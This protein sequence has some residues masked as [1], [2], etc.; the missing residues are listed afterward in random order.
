[1]K[2]L[3]EIIQETKE[4]DETPIAPHPEFDAAMKKLGLQHRG[5]H[6]TSHKSGYHKGWSYD[7][8][9]YGGKV[10]RSSKYNEFGD[11]SS[12]NRK[13]MVSGVVNYM[14]SRGFS[15]YATKGKQGIHW[16]ERGPKNFPEKGR[17]RSHSVESARMDTGHGD[18]HITY[19]HTKTNRDENKGPDSP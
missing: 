14:K 19:T 4:W 13:K 7:S 2:K 11:R 3:R 9:S 8:H 16:F 12:S 18:L 6:H 1:M 17:G 10:P 5:S 15:H